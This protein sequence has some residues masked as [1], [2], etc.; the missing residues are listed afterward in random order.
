[1]IEFSERPNMFSVEASVANCSFRR[2]LKR[3]MSFKMVTRGQERR[4]KPSGQLGPG[5]WRKSRPLPEPSVMRPERDLLCMY[6]PT[7]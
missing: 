5:G 3:L 7:Q 1:M 6:I 2:E 4:Q